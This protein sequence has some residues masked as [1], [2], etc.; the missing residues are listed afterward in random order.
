MMMAVILFTT[1][2]VRLECRIKA[3]FQQER[4]HLLSAAALY[5]LLTSTRQPAMVSPS[6][7]CGDYTAM[8]AN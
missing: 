1:V 7:Q 3:V 8:N 4:V 5:R 6:L 2:H